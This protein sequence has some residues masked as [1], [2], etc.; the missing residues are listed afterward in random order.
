MHRERSTASCPGCNRTICLRRD[1]RAHVHRRGRGYCPGSKDVLVQEVEV[2]RNT[3]RSAPYAPIHNVL[4]AIHR[5]QTG[6]L[7][8]ALG[9]EEIAEL[10]V[11]KGNTYRTLAAL[12]FLDL[13]DNDGRPTAAGSGLQQ[14]S[15]GQFGVQLAQIVRS[16]YAPIISVADPV[17]ASQLTPDKVS[18]AFANLEP[19]AQRERMITLFLGLC[20]EAGLIEARRSPRPRSRLPRPEGE[21]EDGENGSQFRELLALIQRLPQAGKWTPA[22]R[23]RWLHAF[24]ANLDLLVETVEEE[25]RSDEKP[26]TTQ[27]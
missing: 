12:R 14:T 8:G 22:R 16:A 19:K 4:A 2:N 5:L 3:L 27:E 10:G 21:L 15:A 7:T 23:E 11:P 18:S 17:E 24:V 1:G 6:P 26:P 9:I 25:D 20:R 13:L